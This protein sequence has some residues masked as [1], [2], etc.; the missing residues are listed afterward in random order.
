MRAQYYTVTQKSSRGFRQK[1]LRHSF[2]ETV[3]RRRGERVI[4]TQ[5]GCRIAA[6]ISFTELSLSE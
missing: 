3:T 6:L 2:V 5:D 4:L 1:S